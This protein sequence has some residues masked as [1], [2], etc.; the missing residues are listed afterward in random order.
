MEK[1][2]CASSVMGIVVYHI[3]NSLTS[4]TLL[5]LILGIVVGVVIYS[6]MLFLFQEFKPSEIQAL[7]D[8]KAKIRR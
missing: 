2:T 3:D 6:L 7:L 4:S 5:N 1:I 8:L